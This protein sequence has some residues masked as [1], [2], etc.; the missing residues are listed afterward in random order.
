MCVGI[1]AVHEWFLGQNTAE[2][3]RPRSLQ[4]LPGNMKEMQVNA[5]EYLEGG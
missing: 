1:H 2:C 4:P 5:C 3:Y